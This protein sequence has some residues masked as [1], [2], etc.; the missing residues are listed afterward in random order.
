ME[1]IQK[2]TASRSRKTV[3]N[4]RDVRPFDPEITLWSCP[5]FEGKFCYAMLISVP[6]LDWTLVDQKD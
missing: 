6:I 4:S 3:S 1:K 5:Q 2:I